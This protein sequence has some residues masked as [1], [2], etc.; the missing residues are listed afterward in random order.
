[1][2]RNGNLYPRNRD[3]NFSM[4]VSTLIIVGIISGYFQRIYE[5]YFFDSKKMMLLPLFSTS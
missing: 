4:A 5:K 1:M 2:F 3:C